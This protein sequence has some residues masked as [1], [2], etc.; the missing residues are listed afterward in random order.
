MLADNSWSSDQT[1]ATVGRIN[2]GGRRDNAKQVVSGTIRNLRLW[3]G[4]PRFTSNFDPSVY[5]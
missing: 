1:P 4:V 3:V 2:I 5:L